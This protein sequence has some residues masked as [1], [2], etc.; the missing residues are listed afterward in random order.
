MPTINVNFTTIR[1]HDDADNWPNGQGEI[2]YNLLIGD[3]TIA[4][5]P[6]GYPVGV[7]SGGTVFI[8]EQRTLARPDNDAG[9]FFTV[10]GS[11]SEQDSG[12]SWGDDH[13]GSFEHVYN[14]ANNWGQ[15]NHNV[16]LQGDGLDVTV[17]YTI[18]NVGVV[19]HGL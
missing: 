5:R 15:G 12:F 11:V 8:N 2:Y 16:R 6:A 18:S 17:D 9:A 19:D 10:K 7:D 3:T 4:S 14:A 13:A 1:V